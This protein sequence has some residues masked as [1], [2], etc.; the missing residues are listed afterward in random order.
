[1]KS[2]EQKHE[3]EDSDSAELKS[4]ADDEDSTD[5][6]LDAKNLTKKYGCSDKRAC[7]RLGPRRTSDITDS[8]ELALIGTIS[9]GKGRVVREHV[10]E[11]LYDIKRSMRNFE[12]RLS[13]RLA[14]MDKKMNKILALL[15]KK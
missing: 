7:E 6:D 4:L 9:P 10:S 2:G 1:M 8:S 3:R 11:D 14:A 13:D 5:V 15:V 12:Q